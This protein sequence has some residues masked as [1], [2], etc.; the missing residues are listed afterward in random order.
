MEKIEKHW[1]TV[2]PTN[3]KAKHYMTI[4][5]LLETYIL[6]KISVSSLQKQPLDGAAVLSR[7][8]KASQNLRMSVLQSD[9][10]DMHVG[11]KI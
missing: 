10:F 11:I 4:R 9:F 1:H 6:L 5:L 7:I 3:S 8:K 2:P